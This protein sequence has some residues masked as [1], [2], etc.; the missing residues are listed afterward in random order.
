MTPSRLE[1]NLNIFDFQLVEEDMQQIDALNENRR[2][3]P[4]PDKIIY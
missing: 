2:F 4:D 1:E 3:G